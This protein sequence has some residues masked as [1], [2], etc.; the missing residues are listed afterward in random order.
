MIDGT[1]G[2]A[3]RREAGGRRTRAS[4]VTPLTGAGMVRGDTEPAA[5]QPED[6]SVRAKTPFSIPVAWPTSIR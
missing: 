6:R 4:T 1:A 3:R 2:S 5:R